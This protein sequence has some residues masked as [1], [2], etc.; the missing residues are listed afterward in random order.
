MIIMKKLWCLLGFLVIAFSIN[1]QS[2][3]AT[4]TDSV[5]IRNTIMNFYEWYLKNHAKLNSFELYRGFKEKDQPPYRIDWKEAE[6]YFAFIRSSVPQLGEEY[7]KN[8]KT[9]FKECDSAFK[10]D[11]DGDVPYGF[12]YDWYT[13]SQEDAEGIVNAI[14]KSEW[15]IVVN[16]NSAN[17]EMFRDFDDMT[18]NPDPFMC[19]VM[20]KEKG[21]WKIARIGCVSPD[22]EPP[23]MGQ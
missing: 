20:R 13:N 2:G 21:K 18:R 6:R 23:P 8:Q 17:L 19:Y 1:A 3:N 5:Q 14:R 4:T 7:I 22:N 9:F 10:K 12:D 16:G 15:G 11:P